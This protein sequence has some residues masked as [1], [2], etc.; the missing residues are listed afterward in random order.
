MLSEESD[1]KTFIETSHPK[2]SG[3]QRVMIMA[4]LPPDWTVDRLE[5][6]LKDAL[7]ARA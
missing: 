5:R 3:L 6:K 7:N 4:K 1:D 2:L